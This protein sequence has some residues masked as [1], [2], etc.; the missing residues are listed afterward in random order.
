MAVKG[1]GNTEEKN[2]EEVW[3]WGKGNRRVRGRVTGSR[4][5]SLQERVEK[6]VAQ[7]ERAAKFS[8]NTR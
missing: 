5:D 7:E 1:D 3:V 8:L 2:W 4:K 6:Q